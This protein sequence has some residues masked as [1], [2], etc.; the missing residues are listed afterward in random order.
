MQFH[1]YMCDGMLMLTGEKL[2]RI[3]GLEAPADGEECPP[4]TWKTEV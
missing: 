1:G 2:G 3:E 4:A